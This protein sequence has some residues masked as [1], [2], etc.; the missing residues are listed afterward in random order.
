MKE[1]NAALSGYPVPRGDAVLVCFLCL[2]PSIPDGLKPAFVQ[3]IGK[4]GSVGFS[5]FLQ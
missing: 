4:E 3:S 2:S 5:S 1:M